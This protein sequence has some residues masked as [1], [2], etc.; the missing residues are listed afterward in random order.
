LQ[1]C[2][3]TDW[4]EPYATID[5]RQGDDQLLRDKV[6]ATLEQAWL[7]PGDPQ[8][9]ALPEPL[10]KVPALL[11]PLIGRADELAR[12]SELLLLPQVRLVTLLGPGGIGKTHL[13]L[14]V[15]SRMR[16]HF[17]DGVCYISLAAVSDPKLVIPAIAN[18][19]GI[20]E[21]G[22][23]P[24]F[25]L[26]KVAMRKRHLL[27][28]LDNFEQVLN[29]ASQLPEL[30]EEC[31]QLKIMVT[32]RAR[33]HVHGEYGFPVP[34]LAKPD[35]TLP[36]ESDTLTQYASVELFLERARMAR[37]DFRITGTNARAV[38][39]ICVRLD[40][41]P[42]A[43]EL[44]AARIR[45]FA[46]QSLRT[47]LEEHLLDIMISPDQDVDDRQR[48][49]RNTIEWSYDLL[50]IGDQQLF[51][52]L[53]VFAGSWNVEAVEAIYEALGDQGLQVWDGVESLLD[54]SLL[55]PAEKEGEGRFRLLETIREYGLERL[56]ASRE[57]ESVR[58]AHVEYY[59]GLVEEAEPHLKGARQTEWLARLVQEQENQRAAL[60]WLIG[61]EEV[62][63]ALRFCGALWRFWRLRG[64]WSEGRRWL[65][66][67]L[68]LPQD[69]RLM[70]ERAKALCAAGDLAYYQDDYEL[71]HTFLEESVRL[72]RA[73]RDEKELATALGLLGILAQVQGDLEAAGPLLEE[74][75]KLCRKLNIHWELSYLLRKLAGRAAK[76][77]DLKLAAEY[78]QESLALAQKLGDKSL[79]AYVL[80][81]MGEIA[82]RLGGLKQAVA[83]NQESLTLAREIGDKPLI[84]HT[85]NSLGY[86]AALQGDLSFTANVQEA[87]AIFLELDDKMF[88]S[89]TLNTLGYIA[90]HQ[91]NL[92]QA[93]SWFR[94]AL[95]LA[96][97][98]QSEVDVG[99]NLSSLALVAVAEGQPLLAAR[100]FGAVEVKLDV[101]VDMNLAERAEYQRAVES[102]RRQLGVK[103]LASAR[104]EGR[105][106]TI[107]QLLAA[108]YAP[109][110]GHP[111]PSPKYPDGLTEREMQVLC[112]VAKGS[113]DK[114]IAKQLNIALRTVNT[115][116][117][118]IYSKIQAS[119]RWKERAITPRVAAANYATEH[120]LC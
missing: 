42:L 106:M 87:Y 36:L 89:R 96:Q 6:I 10:W 59:L 95:F 91:G 69:A 41:L 26:V 53:C 62:G 111:P 43:I 97:E 58:L 86:F 16:E 46:S 72:C 4:G 52:R 48:T 120:D 17:A 83:C 47:R 114:Q 44:A 93:T 54:K 115:H 50:G 79:A 31:L 117:T 13:G 1:E 102:V 103:A 94:K 119:S 67:A 40:G 85:L 77:G 109:A 107:G 51:R 74:S 37:P 108:S 116:L 3:P 118:S 28:L 99:M 2:L 5:V 98:I 25:E 104:R 66:E 11:M 12:L 55:Q 68:G 88:I 63:L 61:H 19:L 21:T 81:T 18:E 110:I 92:A 33:L 75:E 30:L 49:L 82:G 20:R 64:N 15:A 14:E 105:S 112:L 56:K 60:G 57:A 22:E 90:L 65:E 35:L 78:A 100:L 7:T 70:A 71:A 73:L 80:S 8:T 39:E 34:P 32:S 76:T 24:L 84:A 45:S 38:A 27:L 113:T 29:A 23:R 9:I 101:H